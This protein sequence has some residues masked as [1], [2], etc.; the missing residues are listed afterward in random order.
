MRIK[1]YREYTRES[2]DD[3]LLKLK[4]LSQINVMEEVILMTKSVTIKCDS[5][6]KEIGCTS[7]SSQYYLA[8]NNI[9]MPFA[10]GAV[11]TMSLP[12]LLDDDKHFCCIDCL[13][14]WISD[15]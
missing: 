6:E 5:C 10:G 14:S 2:G 13:K 1:S 11:Y 3:L 8:L 4:K 15:K 12:P 7:F 9:P